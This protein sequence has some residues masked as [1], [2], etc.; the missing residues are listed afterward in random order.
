VSVGKLDGVAGNCEFDAGTLPLVE[1][2]VVC[3]CV[4]IGTIG[5]VAIAP[6]VNGCVLGLGN[7][8]CGTILGVLV[9]G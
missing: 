5:R 7:V 6:G 2:S 1:P 3:V 4:F 8:V 9:S